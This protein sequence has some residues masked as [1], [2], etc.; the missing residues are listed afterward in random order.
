MDRKHG[1][2]RH[3]CFIVLCLLLA[4]ASTAA[5]GASPIKVDFYVIV[6]DR[7][8]TGDIVYIGSEAANQRDAASVA[9]R[10][11][12]NN[13]WTTTLEIAEGQILDYK[14][15][16]GTWETVEKDSTGADIETRSV[17]ALD[18]GGGQLLVID[19]VPLWADELDRADVTPITALQSIAPAY[20]ESDTLEAPIREI[21]YLGSQNFYDGLPVLYLHEPV[22]PAKNAILL[23]NDGT[24]L[25]HR[26][27]ARICAG[28]PNYRL[29][30]EQMPI[31]GLANT[32]SRGSLVTDSA[33]AGTQ[34][35]T[36]YWVNNRTI[37]VD[38]DGVPLKTILEL[39]KELSKSTGII[40]TDSV[41]GATP[42]SFGSHAGDRGDD[43]AISTGIFDNR[44]DVVM[45]GGRKHFV[46]GT[47]N[48]ARIDGRN[49]LK[50][51]QDEGFTVVDNVDDLKA[52]NNLRAWALLNSGSLT[53]AA[54]RNYTL[55][56][57]T[58]EAIRRL[59]QNEN[60]F[61]LMVEGDQIDGGGHNNDGYRVVTEML[62]FETAVQVAVDFASG[63]DDTLVVVVADHETGGLGI[64]S[65]SAYGTSAEIGWVHT[66]HT[67]SPVAVYS[68]G[69]NSVLLGSHMYLANIPK[70]ISLGWGVTDFG[71]E[72][73]LT[74]PGAF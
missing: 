57:L 58:E 15:T 62:D 13:V 41:T 3:L 47:E 69:P 52:D 23:I 42:A 36:G 63:R 53:G 73:E 44:V 18:L 5:V 28:G 43:P 11:I 19:Y 40:T 29:P 34:L 2:N 60:G 46:P 31:V 10:H 14:Y 49:L 64:T 7:T 25:S 24:G 26:T 55:G 1:F 33:A 71:P 16:R 32:H 9:M 67:G 21:V 59:S 65:G 17:V 30:S 72:R 6:P 54:S 20:E 8:P 51:L 66:G 48:G 70:I 27:L 38:P 68:C 39:A 22:K 50:E 45:G 56:D 37:S 74:G 12:G 35:A 4:T 61:F